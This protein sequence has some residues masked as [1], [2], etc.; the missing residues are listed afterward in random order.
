MPTLPKF[1]VDSKFSGENSVYMS[2]SSHL[3][4]STHPN[5]NCEAPYYE[6]ICILPSYMYV[7]ESWYPWYWQVLRPPR[8]GT[9]HSSS[10]MKHHRLQSGDTFTQQDLDSARLRYRLHRK[11]YSHVHDDVTFRV[12]AP[13]CV[14]LSGT[15]ELLH[16]PS[17]ETR[18][19]V[20]ATLE[21]LQVRGT[22]C[23]TDGNY[24]YH[25]F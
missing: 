20:R 17:G 2:Q 4:W 18:D 6:I 9:L 5:E 24:V 22:S 12:S 8:Y 13:E 1:C 23:R 10:S 16:V 19:E 3:L 15:L 21:R 14:P 11:A 7:C 25:P